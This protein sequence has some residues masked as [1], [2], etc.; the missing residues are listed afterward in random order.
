MKIDCTT[1]VAGKQRT[2]MAIGGLD[3]INIDQEQLIEAVR[4]F[5]CLWDVSS[6][7]VRARENAWKRVAE[8]V[9]GTPD[10]CSKKWKNTRD[11]YVR[12]LKKVR[13]KRRTGEGPPPTSS[14]CI[15][16]FCL[17]RHLQ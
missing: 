14:W 4:S 6:G 8:R 15:S 5:P 13:K 16:P 9:G 2:V 1:C 12:E 3:E 10:V 7:D 17:F 11:K